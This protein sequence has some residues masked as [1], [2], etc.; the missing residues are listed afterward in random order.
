MSN[1]IRFKQ[2]DLKK[3]SIR[4][5]GDFSNP[6]NKEERVKDL[7]QKMLDEKYTE[8]FSTGY[9]K[10]K[11]ELEKNFADRVQRKFEEFSRV[12]KAVDKKVS[13]YD[14][15]FED[16]V[17]KVSFEIASKI[18]RRELEKESGIEITLKE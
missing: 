12:L 11:S 9:E 1:I 10:A 13:S 8:G 6:A 2:S 16:L 18:A 14:I 5:K 3:F 4:I 7:H 15:E 17:I